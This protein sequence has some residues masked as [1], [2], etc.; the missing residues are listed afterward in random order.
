M[1]K[2]QSMGPRWE[3]NPRPKLWLVTP[4]YKNKTNSAYRIY[5]IKL[6]TGMYRE[7]MT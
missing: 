3:L 2:Q 5:R 1:Q 7:L 4:D 6:G